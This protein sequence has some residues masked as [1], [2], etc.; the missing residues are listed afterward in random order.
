MNIT[1][2]VPDH[3]HRPKD[4]DILWAIFVE[5]LKESGHCSSTAL[6]SVHAGHDSATLD[7]RSTSVIGD[8]LAN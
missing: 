1:D 5:R 6:V 8:A 3:G 4:S 2:G 7:V